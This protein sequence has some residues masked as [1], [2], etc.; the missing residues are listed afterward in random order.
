MEEFDRRNLAYNIA[1]KTGLDQGDVLKM[2]T[3]LPEI[4]AGAL[5]IPDF[6]GRVEVHGLGTFRLEHR[7]ARHGRTPDGKDWNTPERQEIVFHA[8]P[9][10]A[11]AV[12]KWTDKETY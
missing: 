5:S 12:A 6:G 7:H 1:E 10:L 3:A 4:L 2:L 8:W 9:T 11:Q